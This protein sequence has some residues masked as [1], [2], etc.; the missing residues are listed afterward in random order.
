MIGNT[1]E[2]ITEARKKLQDVYGISTLEDGDEYVFILNNCTLI[3]SVDK[4]TFKIKFIE[5][6]PLKIDKF[7]DVYM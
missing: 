3:L 1:N 5:G 7:C 4:G 6:I 2:I